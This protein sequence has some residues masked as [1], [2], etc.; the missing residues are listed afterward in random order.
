MYTKKSVYNKPANQFS[1]LAPKDEDDNNNSDEKPVN[2]NKV[3]EQDTEKNIFQNYYTDKK[4]YSSNKKFNYYKNQNYVPKSGSVGTG[5][6]GAAVEEPV[7]EFTTVSSRRREKQVHEL[8]VLDVPENILQLNM[9]NYYRVLAH[10][11]ED[12]AWDLNS[13]MNICTL[14]KWIDV[15][16]LF[17][18]L[19]I[20]TEK[21]KLT[22]FDIF[23]MKDD[24]SPLWEDEENRHGSICSVK[25]D[26]LN[27]GYEMLKMLFYHVCNNT[28]MNF[29][30]NYWNNINGVSFSPKKMDTLAVRENNDDLYCVIIKV[31]F[32]T[33]YS[34]L[35]NI[36]KYFNEEVWSV[37]KKY[38]TKVKQIKPEY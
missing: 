33:N 14:V 4:N 34:I 20:T 28:L 21:N 3:V 23:I 35:G 32:K 17:N 26:S 13:Y 1:F 10:H 36:D 16:R 9:L 25:I 8:N 5:T 6:A 27:D 38:S 11:N 7:E 19:N 31:W 29:N 18:T 22:D 12:K 24:I 2:E 37:L 15:A 30:H